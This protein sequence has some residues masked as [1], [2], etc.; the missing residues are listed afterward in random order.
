MFF[1][2]M[3]ISV[4]IK[5]CATLV[6]WKGEQLLELEKLNRS[7]F[8]YRGETCSKFKILLLHRS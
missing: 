6:E 5:T 8:N 3:I 1:K 4:R 2:G 7:S